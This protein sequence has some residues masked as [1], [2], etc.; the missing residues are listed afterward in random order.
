MK[1]RRFFI[2]LALSS[3]SVKPDYAPPCMDIPL[4]W[5]F[6]S[7]EVSEYVNF[8]WWEE[9]GDP[10]LDEMMQIALQ[11][12]QNLQVATARVVEFFAQYRIVAS[13]IFPQIYIDSGIERLKLS[14]AV[15]FQ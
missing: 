11:N 7:Q 3:C 9:L 14:K 13:E 15:D 10:A 12:N 1:L 4:V 5:R 8:A 6:D 2:L